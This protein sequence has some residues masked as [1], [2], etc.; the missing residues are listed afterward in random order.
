MTYRHND[1][2]SKLPQLTGPNAKNPTYEVGYA[3]PPEAA[4]FKKGRSGNPNGRPKGSKSQRPSLGDTQFES[5]FLSEAYRPITINEG[6]REITV[7]RAEAMVRSLYIKGMRGDHRSH[8]LF[9]EVLERA[10]NRRRA[11]RAAVLEQLIGYKTEWEIEF[12]KRERLG[13]T[14]PDPIPHPDHIQIDIRTG[15]YWF[16]GPL[17][18][19]QAK[20][21]ERIREW[22][23]DRENA[24][25]E[26]TK[27]LT[28]V[29]DPGYRRFLEKELEDAT[30][31]L[32]WLKQLQAGLYPK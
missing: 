22:I 26:L 23:A 20:S 17:T 2:R 10:E 28:S 4:R 32:H 14:G 19:E 25:V 13:T 31:R 16:T 15:D 6:G 8:L 18:L 30:S 12:E 3:K 9:F 21:D 11:S 27:E 1:G 29:D 7:T 24:V 5:I